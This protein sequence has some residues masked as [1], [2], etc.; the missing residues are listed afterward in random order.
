MNCT[1]SIWGRQ[2]V[3]VQPSSW[4][5]RENQVCVTCVWDIICY[6]VY[7]TLVVVLFVPLLFLLCLLRKRVDR[8]FLVGGY[9]RGFDR[10]DTHCLSTPHAVSTV[11]LLMMGMGYA[12]NM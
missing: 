10:L 11:K 5:S 8:V 1:H 12:R 6:V 3:C 7:F 4:M 9:K 2:T